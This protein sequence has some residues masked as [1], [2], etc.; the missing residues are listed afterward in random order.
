MQTANFLYHQIYTIVVFPYQ[1]VW[2]SI[3]TRTTLMGIKCR[4][5]EKIMIFGQYLP[6]SWKWYKIGP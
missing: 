1:T 2:D 5:Y 4:G 6:L 3:P